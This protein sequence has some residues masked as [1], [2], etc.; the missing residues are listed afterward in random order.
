MER[1]KI[2]V[3]LQGR[4]GNQL[5]QYSFARK[6]QLDMGENAVIILDDSDVLRCNWENSLVYYNLPDVE[7]V[8]ENIIE[9]EPYIS[10][11]YILRKMEKLYEM[12]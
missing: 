3:P 7:Y 6:I 9:N 12:Q 2:Y 11:Y 4:I 8:H 5:F 10:K 1:N